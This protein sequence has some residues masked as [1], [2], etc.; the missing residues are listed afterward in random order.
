MRRTW[1][2]AMAAA[3]LAMGACGGGSGS[4]SAPPAAAPVPAGDAAKVVQL[5]A[6]S[7]DPLVLASA[8]P[9]LVEFHSPT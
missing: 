5:D 6:G 1:R 4:P 3:A 8:R 2:A 7:F 9:S